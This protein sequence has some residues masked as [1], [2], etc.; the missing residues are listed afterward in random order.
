[1]EPMKKIG[2]KRKTPGTPSSTASS[3]SS[4]RARKGASPA[5]KP[6]DIK[7]DL[8]DVKPETQDEDE[9]DEHEVQQIDVTQYPVQEEH[10]EY[11]PVSEF[12]P[13]YVSLLQ[14]V[15]ERISNPRKEDNLEV[16]VSLIQKTGCFAM[17]KDSFQFD[18]C[19]LDKRTVKKITKLLNITGVK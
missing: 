3:H 10:T 12:T 9:E 8:S 19:L 17:E 2:N 11:I 18:L 15:Q 13:D 16:V 5:S 6:D 1:M 4:K 7:N 14:K